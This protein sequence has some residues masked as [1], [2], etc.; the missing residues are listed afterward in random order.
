MDYSADL[1]EVVVVVGV[2]DGV[3]LGPHDRL[4][5]GPL[6]RGEREKF[7]TM[8]DATQK[9]IIPSSCQFIYIPQRRGY[10]WPTRPRRTTGPRA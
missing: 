4:E 5:V 1:S 7:A 3:V 8:S 9:Q 2:V 10:W 6:Q